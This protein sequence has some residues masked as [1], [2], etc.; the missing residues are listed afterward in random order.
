MEAPRA[1]DIIG[2]VAPGARLLSRLAEMPLA[3]RVLEFDGM[4]VP[5]VAVAGAGADLPPTHAVRSNRRAVHDPV[6]DV[7]LVRRLLHEVVAAEP[8]KNAPMPDLVLHLAHPGR[9]H[10]TRTSPGHIKVRANELHLSNGPVANRAD[11]FQVVPLVAALQSDH[12]REPLALGLG[13]G[14]NQGPVA[15]PVD[16]TG[17]LQESVFA[18]RH[19]RGV[20]H[21]AEMGGRGQKHQVYPGVDD[22]PVGVESHEPPLARHV[23]PLPQLV[24]FGKILQSRLDPRREQIAHGPELYRPLGVQ[25][26]A[27]G[28]RAAVAA[29]DKTDLDGPA[30]RRMRRAGDLQNAVTHRSIPFLAWPLVRLS[31]PARRCATRLLGR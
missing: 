14:R 25:G 27:A 17:F 22:F 11:S 5:D 9:L 18:G 7:D 4:M 3:A 12:H 23:D 31:T 24:V 6:G 26:L 20:L 30:S 19:R 16:A 29:A 2:D 1:M 15:G 13:I 10:F 8:G 28:A 21:G